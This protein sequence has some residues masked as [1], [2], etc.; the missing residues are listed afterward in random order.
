[1]LLGRASTPVVSFLS[2]C[3][4][5]RCFVGEEVEVGRTGQE[6]ERADVLLDFCFFLLDTTTVDI[7]LASGSY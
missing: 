6:A 3:P 2:F 5:W 7:V 1:M 4:S